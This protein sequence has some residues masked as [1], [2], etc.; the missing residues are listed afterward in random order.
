MVTTYATLV[1]NVSDAIVAVLQADA[2]IPTY[3]SK[4]LASTD[5]NITKNLGFF[6]LVHSPTV[7]DSNYALSSRKGVNVTCDIEVYGKKAVSVL[8][9][10]D[11]VRNAIKSSKTTMATTY[12]LLKPNV[13]SSR[14]TEVELP[15]SETSDT[16]YTMLLSTNFKFYEGF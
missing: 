12:K 11:A 2:T 14:I 6:I 10:A 1:K 7:E 5:T 4:I 8:Q 15:D 3:T 9:C 16:L 13:N